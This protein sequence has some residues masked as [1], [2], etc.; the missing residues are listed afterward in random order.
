M[1]SELPGPAAIVLNDFAAAGDKV[2]S[3]KQWEP[4]VW[5]L[6]LYSLLR[7]EVL[8][9][10]EAL[11]LSE[12]FAAAFCRRPEILDEL[13]DIGSLVV[14]KYPRE[15]YP[16]A[17]LQERSL[18]SPM[19]A[20]SQYI[21]RY[22]TRGAEPF[23]PTADQLKIHGELDRILKD[24][25]SAHR[26]TGQQSTIDIFD[27]FSETMVK[28][29]SDRRYRP[30]LLAA[31]PGTT[32]RMLGEFEAYAIEPNRAIERIGKTG[33]PDPQGRFTRSIAYQ[34]AKT[35]G[36]RK[37]PAMEAVIQTVFAYVFNQRERALGRYSSVL[38]EMLLLASDSDDEDD[39][40]PSVTIEAVVR[41]PPLQL[42]K[43]QPGFARIV[44]EVRES[45]AGEKL[46]SAVRL[47]H[48]RAFEE[49]CDAWKGVADEMARRAFPSKPVDLVATLVTLPYR[50]FKATASAFVIE[51]IYRRA[52]PNLTAEFWES[53]GAKGAIGLG[54]SVAGDLYRQITAQWYAHQS[55]R[56]K[57]EELVYFRCTDLTP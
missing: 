36:G 28:V 56:S 47:R 45:K 52:D 1:K 4:F 25:P 8:V 26:E 31:F 22:T 50:A 20:R 19:D 33:R 7:D 34:V 53:F 40:R 37:A 3:V 14:L 2:I 32:N 23:S 5:E 29:L 42:P 30:W 11:V 12:K 15:T 49:Q 13:F 16:D 10:D 35:Y 43:P 18:N 6:M 21:R 51:T 55:F 48:T 39:T 24:R 41:L 46:R 38:R 17:D 9:P 44:R 54:M 27:A 57:L